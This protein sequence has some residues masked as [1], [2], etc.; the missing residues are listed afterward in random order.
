MARILQQLMVAVVFGGPL[1]TS[2]G[3]GPIEAE[4]REFRP[5]YI[6]PD[7]VHPSERINR[8]VAEDGNESHEFRVAALDPN[9]E[10]QLVSAWLTDTTFE[11]KENLSLDSTRP[12]Q[13]INGEA[14]YRY[15]EA[16]QPFVPC[17]HLE[18]GASSFTVTVYITDRDFDPIG[19]DEV[20]VEEGGHV[21]EHS[22]IVQTENC[23]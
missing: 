10:E 16:S 19:P 11:S 23:R 12:R 2:A 21:V 18:D 14:Y 15:E 4:Q 13:Q 22:W 9:R 8:Y 7:S 1:A 17:E 6:D 20:V 3:C 5:P